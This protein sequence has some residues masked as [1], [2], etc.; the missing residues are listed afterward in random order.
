MPNRLIAPLVLAGAVAAAL[1][2]PLGAQVG[3]A[4]PAA[5][6]AEAA[7]A[8]NPAALAARLVQTL[9]LPE[10]IAIMQQEG[11]AYGDTLEAELFPGAGGARWAGIVAVIYDRTTMER[12]FT[13]AF[14][15]E[16]GDDPQVLAPVVDFFASDLGQRILGLEIDARRV[17]LDEA[18]E[19]AAEVA[20][21]A[22]RA[23]N[24]PRVDL[25]LAFA[26]ANDLVEQN[27]AGS[28]NSNLA[29]YRGLAEGGAF[30]GVEMTEADMLAEVW[31]QEAEVRAETERWLH[32]YLAL[33]YRPL[34]DEDLATYT[35][36]SAKPAAARMNAALF[37]A[38]DTV[39]G[40]ISHDLGRAAAE[41][42]AGQD[43]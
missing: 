31:N 20:F 32:S 43:I 37:V 7:A 28:L 17:L 39:F 38:F 15:S 33:A 16:L 22:M 36:F 13:E 9:R 27:V 10:T 5:L 30:A 8:E 18:A 34:S 41:M 23:A 26:Q 29:F 6:P 12:R 40:T 19:E 24:D 1:A 35:A 11:I 2:A 14:L 3:A 42:M 25:L 21:D 4:P